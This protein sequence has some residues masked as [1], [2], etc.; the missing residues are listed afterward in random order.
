MKHEP[1]K[2]IT[3][4]QSEAKLIKIALD[5]LG[6]NLTQHREK[7][8]KDELRAKSIIEKL[9]GLLETNEKSI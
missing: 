2:R 6:I 3:I 5:F 7:Y 4:K 8:A 1:T 9:D